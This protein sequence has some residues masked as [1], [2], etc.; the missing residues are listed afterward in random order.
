MKKKSKLHTIKLKLKNYSKKSKISRKKSI[1][2]STS[3]KT[4]KFALSFIWNKP[5]MNSKNLSE[6]SKWTLAY[7]P[8]TNMDR[9]PKWQAPSKEVNPIFQKNNQC[10]PKGSPSMRKKHPKTKK[11]N[12]TQKIISLIKNPLKKNSRNPP[13]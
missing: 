5:D 8:S 11:I 9:K 3:E 6:T 2:L 10:S 13:I 7:P 12:S 1:K 4:W